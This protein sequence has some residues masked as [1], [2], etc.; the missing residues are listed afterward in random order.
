M[1]RRQ[2]LFSQ[3]LAGAIF[4]WMVWLNIRPIQSYDLW[5]HLAIG[6]E[7]LNR[8]TVFKTDIFS[9]TAPDAYWVNTYWL[10]EV[11]LELLYRSGG[12][13]AI[14]FAKAVFVALVAF[15]AGF[16]LCRPPIPFLIRLCVCVLIFWAGQP[17]GF[18]WIEQASL[19]TLGFLT[20]LLIHLERAHNRFLSSLWL[21][22]FLFILW[23]NMHRGFFVGLVVLSFYSAYWLWKDRPSR[24]QIGFWWFLCMGAT[25][26]NPWGIGVFQMIFD[27]WRFSPQMGAAWLPTPWLR[28]ELFW[29]VVFLFGISWLYQ[30]F[31]K[32]LSNFHVGRL[33]TGGLLLANAIR[34]VSQVPYFVV[35]AI[36]R[37]FSIELFSRFSFRHCLLLIILLLGFSTYTVGKPSWGVWRGRFPVAICNFIQEQS[38]TGLFYND[39]PFGGYLMWRFGPKQPVFI[40]GRYPAV[41]GY[42]QLFRHISEAQRGSAERWQTFLASHDI[43]G[44]L[45]TYPQSSSFPSTFEIYFPKARWALVD[46]DD[47]GLLYLRRD[48][49]P[50]KEVIEQFEYRTLLPDSRLDYFRVRWQQSDLQNQQRILDEL[51]SAIVRH[52]EAQ[53]PRLLKRQLVNS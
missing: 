53:R 17:R 35:F 18:G 20:L 13:H 30:F 50:Y 5:W 42:V 38:L 51:D 45:M 7:M 52:P 27:D 49:G 14:I 28:M 19:V 9:F 23:A 24:I 26:I 3:V 4:I 12:L 6:R 46:W 43:T 22:P 15:S 31:K 25:L 34:F 39:Y 40:D 2:I 41:A 21:W 10:T 29:I 48:Y 1:N 16:G 11:I 44:A 8:G 47:V 37:V 33:A 36:P 32:G